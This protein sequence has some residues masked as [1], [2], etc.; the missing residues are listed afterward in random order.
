MNPPVTPQLSSLPT[1]RIVCSQ[2]H[3]ILEWCDRHLMLVKLLN[4]N[5]QNLLQEEVPRIKTYVEDLEKLENVNAEVTS[6]VDKSMFQL[7]MNA[8]TP[9]FSLIH[10]KLDELKRTISY[11]CFLRNSN[12]IKMDRFVALVGEDVLFDLHDLVHKCTPIPSV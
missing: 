11:L 2:A 1:S 8:F 3:Q 7:A 12:N 5:F 4:K 6:A 9:M 10:H